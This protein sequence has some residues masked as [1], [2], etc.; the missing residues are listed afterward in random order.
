MSRE[1]VGR[2]EDEKL[3]AATFQPEIEEY[4]ARD[5]GESF[6][7]SVMGSSVYPIILYP[8]HRYNIPAAIRYKRYLDYQHFEKKNGRRGASIWQR[9]GFSFYLWYE[10]E[11]IS[12]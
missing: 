10:T 8:G 3:W 5:L 11:P 2:N 6:Q 4:S 12:Y 1:R 7:G 9:T